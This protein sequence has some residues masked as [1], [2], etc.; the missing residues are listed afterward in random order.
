MPATVSVHLYPE[1]PVRVRLH[2]DEDRAVVIW[3][4]GSAARP[5]WI[6]YVPRAE[7]VAL[8]DTLTD[9]GDRPRHR[10]HRRHRTGRTRP[11]H[12]DG[13]TATRTRCAPRP[14]DGPPHHLSG[15]L[16]PTHLDRI[17]AE[18]GLRYRHAQN[19]R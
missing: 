7:L 11:P 3:A 13:G 19:R 18:C 1:M 5:S 9:R 8:R 16:G 2:P 10:P 6:V 15:P 12:S 17:P 14:P 4:S